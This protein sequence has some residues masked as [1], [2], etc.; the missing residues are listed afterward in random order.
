MTSV[1]L[2]KMFNPAVTAYPLDIFHAKS[3]FDSD[4]FFPTTSG[5]GEPNEG[6]SL[7]VE[8]NDTQRYGCEQN[9]QREQ[10]SSLRMQQLADRVPASHQYVLNKSRGAWSSRP[11]LSVELIEITLDCRFV[12]Q[13]VHPN[14][15]RFPKDRLCLSVF[16]GRSRQG[17]S[18][19]HYQSVV[20]TQR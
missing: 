4:G 7:V 14:S 5:T 13:K 15:L 12:N 16:E 10:I 9:G 2:A 17:L 8:G 3:F 1:L 6:F 20:A 18:A 19:G 11:C